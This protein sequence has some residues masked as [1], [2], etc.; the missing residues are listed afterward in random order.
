MC[1]IFS[2][3][4]SWWRIHIYLQHVLQ[5]M[6]RLRLH[7]E[8]MWKAIYEQNL[9]DSLQS[10]SFF[11]HK[12]LVFLKSNCTY[13][14]EQ[15]AKKALICWCN[16]VLFFNPTIWKLTSPAYQNTLMLNQYPFSSRSNLH[17]NRLYWILQVSTYVALDYQT[18][19]A[20]DQHT[21]IT[22]PAELTCDEH[23]R[24]GM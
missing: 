11:G 14:I 4:V 17:V 7:Y 16:I 9:L 6:L 13:I 20:L 15:S 5:L 2:N 22:W 21:Q 8:I 23:S 3:A 1:V 10:S 19:S 18:Y 12:H 24:V